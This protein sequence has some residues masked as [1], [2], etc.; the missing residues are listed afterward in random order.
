MIVAVIVTYN[1]K[2]LLGENIQMLLGG[3]SYHA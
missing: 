1:R 2:E 3:G